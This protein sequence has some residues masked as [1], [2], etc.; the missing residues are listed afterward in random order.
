MFS[1]ASELPDSGREQGQTCQN[2]ARKDVA[3]PG[4]EILKV[5]R[6]SLF[7]GDLHTKSADLRRTIRPSHSLSEP[8]RN[9]A[10]L[11][12]SS[13]QASMP[14]WHLVFLLSPSVHFA[15][16]FQ[17]GNRWQKLDSAGKWLNPL[18]YIHVIGCRFA[19][20][21]SLLSFHSNS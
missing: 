18:K 21:T 20:K 15:F 2:T 4:Q 5:P 7:L 17:K 9:Q 8:V 1:C 11:G 6:D 13:I 3:D 19:I 12:S 16:V 14:T 10:V